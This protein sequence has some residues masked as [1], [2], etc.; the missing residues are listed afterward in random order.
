MSK[1]ELNQIDVYSILTL[2]LLMIGG[3]VLLKISLAYGFA[4]SIIAC[5][6]RFLMK[7]FTFKELSCM[8]I[9]GLS[10]CKLLYI[11]I[12]LIGATVSI[13][14]SSGVVPSMVYYGFE[15]MKDMNFLFAAFMIMSI[16][17]VFMG[18]AVGTIST[19]GIAILGIGTGFGVPSYVLLG[20]IVSGAFIADKISPISGLLNL[21]LTTTSTNYKGAIKTMLVTLIPTLIIT[22][23]VYYLLGMKYSGNID[24]SSITEF[25]HAISDAFFISPFLL[26]MPVLI[27]LLSCFGAKT[28][29]S[30][31]SGLLCGIAISLTLQKMTF[32]QVI[33]AILF[34]YKGNTASLKLN[35]ILISGGM[36]SMVEVLLIVMGAIALSSML[37]GTG[38]IYFLTNKVI[39]GIKN[40]RDLIFKTSFISSILT[41]V[42]C[43]QT[44]GIVL[45]GR[46]LAKK[47]DELNIDRTVL[48]RT[49]SD[50][51]TIIAPLMPW[52]V[53]SL[54]IVIVA[55]T[56]SGYAPFAVLC[57]IA[58]VVTLIVGALGNRKES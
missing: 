19:I 37:E 34:G 21:T 32:L 47:C 15:Y 49:I 48:A 46:L 31:L 27:V 50:T 4:I 53:N 38:L 44:M 3:C 25:Q 33:K 57:Y 43:D 6:G 28:I 18:T 12:M 5:F 13:W 45:P 39:A 8:M 40:R 42:T 16:S 10:E 9:K 26:L 20:V 41:V 23:A 1:R 52:N 11:L 56:V 30:I 24:T 51:G 35:D 36:V 29:Y 2:C 22:S 17:A 54:I 7:G 58:P 55:G 14:L